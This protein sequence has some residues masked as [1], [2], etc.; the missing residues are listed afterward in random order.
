[1][2]QIPAID[3]KRLVV[4]LLPTFMRFPALYA[5]LYAMVYPVSTLRDR[6]LKNR[7]D[8]LYKINQTGQVCYLRG[9][10]ND[11]FDP[12]QRRILLIDGVNSDWQF[13]YKEQTF[14]TT[15]KGEPLYVAAANSITSDSLGNSTLVFSGN[16]IVNIP[17]RGSIGA[18]GFDFSIKLP[19]ELRGVAD[20]NHLKALV[21]YYKLA[22]KRYDIQYF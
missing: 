2:S 9:M 21:N 8:N 20:E 6:F 22:S 15:D 19:M 4:Q 13:T 18:L 3:Y 1:M 16:T 12:T 11:N 7:A 17:K 10:L 5:L 14:N